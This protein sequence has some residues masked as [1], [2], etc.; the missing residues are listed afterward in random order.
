[1]LL[2]KALLA[3]CSARYFA[4]Y[5]FWVIKLHFCIFNH[6]PMI[7]FS[8]VLTLRMGKQEGMKTKNKDK[9]AVQNVWVKDKL[10]RKQ[11][12]FKSV[13]LRFI[14]TFDSCLAHMSF[15]AS[16]VHPWECAQ[17]P[18]RISWLRIGDWIRQTGNQHQSSAVWKTHEQAGLMLKRMHC[19]FKLQALFNMRV[20]SCLIC[21]ILSWQTAGLPHIL[22]STPLQVEGS[23]SPD[24]LEI[25]SAASKTAA[26][27]QWYV[28]HGWWRTGVLFETVKKRKNGFETC[29][30]FQHE[31]SLG[32][33]MWHV[34]YVWPRPIQFCYWLQSFIWKEV[35]WCSGVGFWTGMMRLFTFTMWDVDLTFCMCCFSLKLFLWWNC[36]KHLRTC[37][38]IQVR[39]S[40]G[41]VLALVMAPYLRSQHPATCAMALN[42]LD[43]P[44]IP[45]L[46]KAC[47]HFEIDSAF[48]IC[49]QTWFLFTSP[50][51]QF[52]IS[53]LLRWSKK[54]NRPLVGAEM[55]SAMGLPVT[56]AVANGLG[57][58][59]PDV[60]ML[61]DRA[62]AG[63]EIGC[64]IVHGC[65]MCCAV[66]A[67]LAGNGMDIPCVGFI[68]LSVSPAWLV[69]F[70]P[71]IMPA[72]WNTY[73]IW[74]QAL[75]CIEPINEDGLTNAF[76]FWIIM[77]VL[78]GMCFFRAKPFLHR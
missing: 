1:M 5:S 67:F 51:Q 10:D 7:G 15:E 3:C 53:A 42:H 43:L 37:R 22:W 18:W 56:R 63:Q 72:V 46:T 21:H 69:R 60:S 73:M 30:T 77:D 58:S 14:S 28:L 47:V 19:A 75:I 40:K 20:T 50:P 26:H 66:Q 12:S 45:Y 31:I 61:K 65:D 64:R 62:K 44:S 76:F 24:H 35:S 6:S 70:N 27:C 13:L 59:T 17:V 41:V 36:S 29:W 34:Q 74:S 52:K 71:H 16:M 78:E 32:G 9:K 55:L 57:L 49:F 68:I 11:L 8:R 25:D 4:T 23:Q 39:R 38:R 33:R 48:K 2:V 54:Y